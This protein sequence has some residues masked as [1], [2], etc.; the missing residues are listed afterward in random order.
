MSFS[1]WL[2][3]PPFPADTLQNGERIYVVG[4]YWVVTDQGQPTQDQINAVINA[5]VLPN[6]LTVADLAKVLTDKGVLTTQ[7]LTGQS[8]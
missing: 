1:V 3:S 4:E 2:T 7:D 8:T 6:A 5:P